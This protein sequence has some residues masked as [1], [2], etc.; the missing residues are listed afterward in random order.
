M[1]TQRKTPAAGTGARTTAHVEAQIHSSTPS[2]KPR[3]LSEYLFGDPPDQRP[4]LL[5]TE[6]GGHLLY[7]REINLILGEPESGKSW[8][9]LCA[10]LEVVRRAGSVLYIDYEDSALGLGGRLRQMVKDDDAAK[11]AIAQHFLYVAPFESIDD[12]ESTMERFER[13]PPSLVVVDATIE[14]CATEG[15]DTNRDVDIAKFYARIP[16]RFQSMGSTVLLL[17]HVVKD[18][19]SRGRWALGSGHKIGALTGVAYSVR[20]EEPFYRGGNGRSVMTIS[21]DRIGWCRAAENLSGPV[22]VDLVSTTTE[23]SDLGEVEITFTR[24]KTAKS[25]KGDRDEKLERRVIQF[26][27][28]NPGCSTR[29]LI[30]GVKGNDAKIGEAKAALL[31]RGRIRIDE[32]ETGAHLHYVKSS[33]SRLNPA[34]HPSR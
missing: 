29:E 20:S 19:S 30:R 28:A 6:D 33:G 14:A 26:I 17:D 8:I 16:R 18:S 12:A 7:E 2:W 23:G 10:A 9:A 4:T 13:E 24:T 11:E 34:N 1:D 32:T 22:C 25:S 3:S 15:L 5:A 21:K 27:E 31:E